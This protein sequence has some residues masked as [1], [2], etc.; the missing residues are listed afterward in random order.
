[1]SSI[2]QVIIIRKDL[3]MRKG[4][5]CVQASHCSMKVFFDR[6]NYFHNYAQPP[7]VQYLLEVTPAMKEWIEGTFTKI[8]VGCNSL[9]ELIELSLKAKEKNIPYAVIED[10]GKTEFKEPT[11]TCLAIGPDE[12][13]KIDEIT[14]HLELL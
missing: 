11:I 14:G 5:M 12:S 1:M 3:N 2:K 10:I 7:S 4:K 13:E 9:E 6:L 8:V